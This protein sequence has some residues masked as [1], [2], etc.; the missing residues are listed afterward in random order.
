MTKIGADKNHGKIFE[1]FFESFVLVKFGIQ[2]LLYSF[3]FP[4]VE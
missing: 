3:F 1:N 4:C 2:P